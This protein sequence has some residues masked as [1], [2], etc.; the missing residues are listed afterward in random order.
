MKEE[1]KKIKHFN[2]RVTRIELDDDKEEW[3]ISN[4]AKE[5]FSTKDL[6]ELLQF[7]MENRN[8]LRCVEK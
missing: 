4:L 2:L 5:K 6:K 7:K 3:L 1:L 8:I